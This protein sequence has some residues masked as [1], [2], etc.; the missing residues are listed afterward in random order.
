[1]T[2]ENRSP[3]AR[4]LLTFARRRAVGRKSRMFRAANAGAMPAGQSGVVE[5]HAY[6]QSR[7]SAEDRANVGDAGLT[8]C[9]GEGT[10]WRAVKATA[11]GW[12]VTTFGTLAERGEPAF[13]SFPLAAASWIATL[14]LDGCAAY[15]EG[16]YPIFLDPPPQLDPA[17]REKPDFEGS[18]RAEIMVLRGDRRG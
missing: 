10:W 16:M 12:M 5:L 17:D 4:S 1:M 3:K 18:K 2:C 13:S 8:T 7:R 14:V 11:S 9:P 6:R 15:A